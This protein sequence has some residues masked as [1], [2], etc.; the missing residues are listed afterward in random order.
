MAD[1]RQGGDAGLAAAQRRNTARRGAVNGR[2]DLAAAALPADPELAQCAAMGWAR[3]T[4]W[5]ASGR[6]GPRLR[7]FGGTLRPLPVAR[8]MRRI[9]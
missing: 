1:V 2:R 3:W 7:L 6:F 9:G 4:I 5:T 8:T